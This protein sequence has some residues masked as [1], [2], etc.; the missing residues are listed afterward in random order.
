MAGVHA[1]P[2][3]WLRETDSEADMP[4][5]SFLMGH[6]AISHIE[7]QRINDASLVDITGFVLMVSGMYYGC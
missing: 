2:L 6:M 1:S 7:R 3:F 5:C 4:D